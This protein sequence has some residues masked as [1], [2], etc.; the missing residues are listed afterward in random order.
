M[1]FELRPLKWS[2]KNVRLYWLQ[3]HWDSWNDIYGVTLS[4]CL[5]SHFSFIQP[6]LSQEKQLSLSN[7]SSLASTN[8]CGWASGSK[9]DETSY[10]L[11]EAE[12]E[13][14]SKIF[15]ELTAV[16]DSDFEL[17]SHFFKVQLN[18]KLISDNPICCSWNWG[19][20][21]WPLR[22][23]GSWE[24]KV[25]QRLEDCAML[26]FLYFRMAQK[27]LSFSKGHPPPCVMGWMDIAYS[28]PKIK[29]VLIHL[30]HDSWCMRSWR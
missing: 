27:A 1:Y 28:K 15:K 22:N 2:W 8:Q 30:L 19:N 10:W 26:F 3:L 18:L 12:I 6:F 11:N 14:R 21:T 20:S 13:L 9:Y 17:H 25:V 29:T 5:H 16:V 24:I 4:H 23:G 7:V